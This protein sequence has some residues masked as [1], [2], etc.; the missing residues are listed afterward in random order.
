MN[1]AARRVWIKAV[2]LAFIGVFAFLL[3]YSGFVS[4]ATARAVAFC[5][6]NVIPSLFIYLVFSRRITAITG[7]TKL[8]AHPLWGSVFTVLMGFLCGYPA[9]ARNCVSLYES[10]VISKKRGEYLCCLCSGA[11]VAFVLAFAG[12]SVMGSVKYG[13][14][15]LG[16]QFAA[17]LVTAVLFYPFLLKNDEKIMQ[18]VT[19]VYIRKVDFSAAVS[20]SAFLMVRIC[21]FIVCF[22]VLGAIVSAVFPEQS[23][24]SVLVKGLFEFSS[25]IAE[26][27][28]YNIHTR[29][30][31]CSLFLGFGSLSAIFQTVSVVKDVFSVKPFIIS[32][33]VIASLMTVFALLT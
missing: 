5:L 25:G 24:Q 13:F 14:K 6:K 17:T 7:V 16:F 22:F 23:L 27:A 31:L 8:C 15:L 29:E 33:L 19:N 28:V 30:L 2:N 21:G 11:S 26:S 3:V 20:E 4:A 10:G 1:K 18:S 12:A 9:G 32:R